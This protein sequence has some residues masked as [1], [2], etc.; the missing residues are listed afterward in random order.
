MR[1][2]FLGTGTSQGVPVIAC[3]CG[4]CRS[5]DER[6]R[7]LRTSALLR[8]DGGRNILFDIGP[9]FR[10]QMLREGVER[11]DAILITHAHR[12]H[13]GGLDDIRSFNYVQGRKMDVYLNEEAARAIRNDYHY[14]FEPHVY[15]G[16]PEAELH[17][18]GL[19]GGGS[20]IGEGSVEVAGV[21][22]TPIKAMHK[23]LPV[24]GYRVGKMAYVTDANYIAEEEQEKLR[25]LKVLVLNALRKEKHFSHFCLGEALELIERVKP[26]RALLTHISHEMGLHAEVSD[27]LPAGVELAY[28]GEE[29]EI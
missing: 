17:V 22:V 28:D 18:L 6:D 13:V 15:P 19:T 9:D 1:L 12:D 5:T 2:T 7:R 10:Q 21:M 8:T 20:P 14:I 16:L 27:E 24:L 25:G 4:V 23:D 3:H 11:L 26:E 29:V